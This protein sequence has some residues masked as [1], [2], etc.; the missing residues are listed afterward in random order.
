M[1]AT[2]AQQTM[3]LCSGSGKEMIMTKLIAA[4]LAF[5][6]LALTTSI[7]RPTPSFA[8]ATTCS[9]MR[10]QC[11]PLARNPKLCNGAWNRCMKSGR[12]I[13]PET[14]RDLGPAEKK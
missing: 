6:F 2:E 3:M 5:G 4:G 7:V 12:W 14:G 13:G 1:L 9:S 8:Q 11:R 10:D